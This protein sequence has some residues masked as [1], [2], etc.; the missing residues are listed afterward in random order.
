MARKPQFDYDLI[1]I[2][3]GAAGS[4][5]A[6]IATQNGK[7]VAI[8]EKDI[9]GGESPNWGDIPVKS[10][11]HATH[12]YSEA[13]DGARFGIR[14]STIGYN[15]MSLKAWKD[16]AIKRT[17]A[18]NNRRY[19]EKQGISTYASTAHFLS[20]HEIAINRRHL[21]AANFLIAAGS[22]WET[23]DIVG[24]KNIPF[25]TPRDI[26][27]ITRPPKSLLIL[28]GDSAAVEYAQLFAAF[29]TKVYIVER[30]GRLLPNE[31]SEAGETLSYILKRKKGVEILTETR[32]LSVEKNG[33][34]KKIIYLR[35]GQE[36][37]LKVD[38]IL[39]TT[40]RTPSVDIGLENAS[41]RYTPKG[42]EV[43]EFLQTSTKHIFAAGDVLG[44]KKQTQTALIESRIAANNIF[45][46]Q[47]VAPDYNSVPNITFTNPGVA[48]VGLSEDDCLKRDLD[49]NTAIAPLNIIA[50]SN[51]SDFRDGFVKI[52]ADRHGVILGA[53]VVAPH[54]GEIIHELALAVKYG[55]TAGELA[56]TPHAFLSWSEAVR[57]A[58]SR[59]S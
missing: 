26:L 16:L 59:L 48:S 19:Y 53:T 9:F 38:E 14:S 42:V 54:A 49:I 28:G 1:V 5:A 41:V 55:M 20:P 46:K 11:L 27:D 51:T 57:V 47:K 52:I 45:N 39:V 37:S 10:L 33:T 56:V 2:G 36:K 44:A 50:R 23:P 31:D 22:Y 6:T 30:A 29:G 18:G 43:N 8:V 15:F 25:Y 7:K 3:S 4:P 34:L 32:I 17:G 21:T 40:G 58:A 24:L 35:G 13:K 12:L